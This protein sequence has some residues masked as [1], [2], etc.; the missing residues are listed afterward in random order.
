MTFRDDMAMVLA[1]N[2]ILRE[3]LQGLYDETADYIR[4]N[5]L[6][7]AHHNQTMK[8]AREALYSCRLESNPEAKP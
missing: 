5:N 4:L 2:Y 6:G 7:D 1:H 3:A 8:K